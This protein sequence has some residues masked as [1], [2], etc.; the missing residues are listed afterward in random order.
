M[1]FTYFQGRVP[2]WNLAGLLPPDP[3]S[4]GPGGPS[5]GVSAAAGGLPHP[6]PHYSGAYGAQ[7]HSHYPHILQPHG[8]EPQHPWPVEAGGAEATS[9]TSAMHY[10]MDPDASA[11]M[12]MYYS[13]HQGLGAG[14]TSTSADSPAASS[15]TT[16][17]TT[18]APT[19]AET[20]QIP[21][22]SIST[23][24]AASAEA[25]A[26]A[27]GQDLLHPYL[28]HPSGDMPSGAI[29]EDYGS[30][31]DPTSQAAAAAAAAAANHP[32]LD[33][34]PDFGLSRYVLKAGLPF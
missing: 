8:S 28:G 2:A 22:F 13:P 20:L 21:N 14:A 18:T 16:P 3:T 25:A 19:S 17:V 1:Y 15:A 12:S 24:T 23:S 31:F 5:P 10:K 7:P 9:A 34:Y 26:A 11:V 30:V 33:P 32:H 4:P 27:A 29:P 6:L